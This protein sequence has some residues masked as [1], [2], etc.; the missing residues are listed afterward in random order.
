MT[1]KE[2]YIDNQTNK[3]TG[4]KTGR[5]E[6]VRM[7]AKYKKKNLSHEDD[8]LCKKFTSKKRLKTNIYIFSILLC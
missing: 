8:I 6:K 2:R 3:F 5:Q 4:R 7:S 1:D